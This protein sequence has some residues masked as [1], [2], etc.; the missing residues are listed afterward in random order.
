MPRR[1]ESDG[2]TRGNSSMG[3]IKGTAAGMRGNDGQSG[4]NR[5][6]SCSGNHPLKE[7]GSFRNMPHGDRLALVRRA[8]LCDNCLK[9]GHMARGCMNPSGCEI[10]GCKRKHDTLLH[11]DQPNRSEGSTSGD[12]AI[13]AN[14][15]HI[16][17]GQCGAI[18]RGRKVRLRI[19][20][21]KV[22]C[23]D[24]AA[25]VETYALLD[26]GSDVSLCSKRLS[27][28]LGAKGVPRSFSLTTR[29]KCNSLKTGQEVKLTVESLDGAE[30][31]EIPKAWTV[32][33]LNISSHSIATE[34]DLADWPHLQGIELPSV[35]EKEVGLLIG[36]DV[37]MAFW[38]IDKSRGNRGEPYAVRS[39]PWMDLAGTNHQDGR[40]RFGQ[41]QFHP[42]W[43]RWPIYGRPTVAAGQ[44][45]L[46]SG[47]RA[48]LF[49]KLQEVHVHRGQ[50]SPQHNGGVHRVG[51]RPLLR[52]LVV[53]AEEHVPAKQLTH[54][55]QKSV[56][57]QTQVARGRWAISQVQGLN[58]RLLE[59]GI[60]IQNLRRRWCAS[61]T[62]VVVPTPPPCSPSTETWKSGGSFR[63]RCQ[64]PRR[65]L[66]P[67]AH[68][69][70]PDTT[71]DLV[72]VLTRFRQD[73]VAIVVDIEAM[74][75]QVRVKPEDRD[76]LRF[77][78]WPGGDLSSTPA[79]YRMNAHLFGER[80]SSPSV[81]GYCLQRTAE[82]NEDR[83]EIMSAFWKSIK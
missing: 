59:T 72:G 52:C 50:K 45:I 49:H 60:R 76:A 29:E 16:E 43:E 9:Q 26:N 13:V 44:T 65:L 40:G 55:D 34:E 83:F 38:V 81:A 14:H 80:T 10:D 61:R 54:G 56:L 8:K 25:V 70:G 77:L 48:S 64:V 24:G 2:S 42:A 5:C 78:W 22:Q 27:D 3:H 33:C 4:S 47:Q 58:W 74:F 7:C 46:G 21:V 35:A 41:C 28:Q 62:T 68:L 15:A 30:K 67:A 19:V 66:E 79:E 6:P 17:G 11:F 36:S 71:N 32:D 20:P 73:Q 39:P 53:E 51:R 31:I 57:S 69:Q 1:R 18:S 75:H 82:D 37:P 63:L 23:D 12:D